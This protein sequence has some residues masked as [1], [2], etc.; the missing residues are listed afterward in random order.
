IRFELVAGSWL[1]RHEGNQ[2][3]AIHRGQPGGVRSRR[4]WRSAKFH[5]GQRQLPASVFG[6]HVGGSEW[7]VA[8]RLCRR[9]FRGGKFELQRARNEPEEAVQPRAFLPGVV[10]VVEDD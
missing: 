1:R 8:L 7:A 10:Y 9:G 5:R 6:L 4:D 2:T 3:T